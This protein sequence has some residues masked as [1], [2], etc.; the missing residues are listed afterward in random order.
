MNKITYYIGMIFICI[1]IMFLSNL[2]EKKMQ[3]NTC[4]CVRVCIYIYINVSVRNFK[5]RENTKKF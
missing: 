2:V 4:V 3:Y 1:N 5:V